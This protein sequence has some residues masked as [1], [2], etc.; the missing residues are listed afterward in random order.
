M[1]SATH[2][3]FLRHIKPPTT[4]GRMILGVYCVEHGLIRRTRLSWLRELI[5]MEPKYKI[6]VK[7]RNALDEY[8]KVIK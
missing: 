2:A 5:G 8:E 3:Y 6:T 7:G 4:L 1:I